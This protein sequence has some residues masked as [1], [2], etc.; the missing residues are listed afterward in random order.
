MENEPA[1]NEED[2]CVVLV[3]QN[4]V[5]DS[6]VIHAKLDKCGET[7]HNFVCITYPCLDEDIKCWE[8]NTSVQKKIGQEHGILLSPKLDIR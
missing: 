6:A 7:V 4:M 5:D 1:L 3:L 2:Q 8:Q